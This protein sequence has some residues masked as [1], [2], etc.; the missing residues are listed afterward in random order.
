MFHTSA[1]QYCNSNNNNNNYLLHNEN[2]TNNGLISFAEF[3]EFWSVEIVYGMFRIF[4]L[5]IG[6][7]QRQLN[8]RVITKIKLTPSAGRLHVY[9]GYT[10]YAET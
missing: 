9:Y 4:I 8:K 1:E 7:E 2:Q 3:A 5:F 10:A 6:I